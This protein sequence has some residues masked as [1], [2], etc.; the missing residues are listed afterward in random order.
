MHTDLIAT[1]SHLIKDTQLSMQLL[2]KTESF[3]LLS[4]CSKQICHRVSFGQPFKSI[5]NQTEK[6]ITVKLH[7]IKV[8][9]LLGLG[10]RIFSTSLFSENRQTQVLTMHVA[11]LQFTVII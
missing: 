1:P 10:M 9:N 7:N 3:N 4:E 11:F 6:Y 2:E 5:P 8:H